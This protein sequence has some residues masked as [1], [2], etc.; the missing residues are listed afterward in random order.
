MTKRLY[1]QPTVNTN[2]RTKILT[3]KEEYERILKDREIEI[4]DA[5]ES[6]REKDRIWAKADKYRLLDVIA[7]LEKLLK[8]P[9][10]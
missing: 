7:A 1:N 5:E 8:W 6:R 9:N 4:K 3:L 2:M 10:Y